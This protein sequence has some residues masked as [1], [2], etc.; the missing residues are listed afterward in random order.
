MNKSL[1]YLRSS[2][3]PPRF[4]RVWPL[5]VAGLALLSACAQVQVSSVSPDV[6]RPAY[7]L[8]GA[9]VAALQA[10][11]ARLCPQ[12]FEVQRQS[13]TDT[14]QPGEFRVV[15]WWNQALT[16]VADDDRQAQMAVSCQNK[17]P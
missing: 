14:K 8:R 6:K 17:A 5:C 4:G 7:E 16:W 13:S 9:T 10:E 12:G 3:V 2:F 1:P 11:A 15:N